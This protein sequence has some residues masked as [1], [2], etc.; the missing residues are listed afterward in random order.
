MKPISIQRF[1]HKS[2]I[3]SLNP[4]HECCRRMVMRLREKVDVQRERGVDVVGDERSRG[5]GGGKVA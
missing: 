1:N 3:K 4:T 2:K 5:D